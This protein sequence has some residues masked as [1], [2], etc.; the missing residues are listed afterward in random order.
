[1]YEVFDAGFERPDNTKRPTLAKLQ[2]T[3]NLNPTPLPT[4]PL[5]ITVPILSP[6]PDVT[7]C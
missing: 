1:M 2:H 6:P 3:L 5:P 7:R 4:I